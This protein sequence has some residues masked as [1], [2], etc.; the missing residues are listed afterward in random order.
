[1]PLQI[2][3]VQSI[4]SEMLDRTASKA[5]VHPSFAIELANY[6]R[7]MALEDLDTSEVSIVIEGIVEEAISQRA[8]RLDAGAVHAVT[9]ELCDNPWKA[10]DSISKAILRRKNMPE[11]V[12]KIDARIAELTKL[13]T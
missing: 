5:D 6:S 8:P 9:F 3:D 13:L 11:A 7:R 2:T 1:M 12:S 10:C 4:L